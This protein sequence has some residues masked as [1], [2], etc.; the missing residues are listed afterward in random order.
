[1]DNRTVLMGLSFVVMWSSAFTSARIAVADAPPFLLLSVRFL[2]SGLL[3]IAIARA[4]GQRV[5]L[6]RSAWISVV[7]FG[8][9][10]NTLYLGLN[11]TAMQTVEASVAVIV[12]SAL[13]LVVAA[14]RWGLF[15]ERPARM[16][17]L[18]L[19]AGMLGVLVIM[20]SRL[21]GG[22]DPF[23]V[24]LCVAGLLSLTVATLVVT[25]ASSGGNVLMVVGL[26]MLVGSVTLLPLSAAFEVW[27][28]NWTLSLILAFTYTTLIPGLAA[29]LIWFLLVR[30]IGATRAASFHFLNPFIGVAIAALVLSEALTLRDFVGVFVIMLGIWAVQT[31]GRTDRNLWQKSDDT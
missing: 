31:A 3:A 8:I 28:V 14:A 22:A 24:A 30:R 16:G 23:G 18:G 13:P 2:L 25:G 21:E 4:L 26:Q 27:E 17:M 20:S 10:Q 12:A 9:C 1:M 6:S 5:A 11:F 19:A 29:T 15:G 7:L